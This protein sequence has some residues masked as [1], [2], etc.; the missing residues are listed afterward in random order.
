MTI[1]ARPARR[2]EPEDD[3]NAEEVLPWVADPGLEELSSSCRECGATIQDL[4]FRRNGED[5]TVDALQVATDTKKQ[6]GKELCGTCSI[7]AHKARKAKRAQGGQ[8][9]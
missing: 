9:L 7:E 6:F 5:V 3:D 4:T 8:G 2:A 1:D